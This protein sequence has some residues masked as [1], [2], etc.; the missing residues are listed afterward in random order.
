MDIDWAPEAVIEDTLS[1][2]ESHGVCCTL[3][4]THASRVLSELNSDLFEVGLHPN[5]N[6][7]LGGG[8][9]DITSIIRSLREL[10]PGAK[11]IRSHSLTQS[12]PVLDLFAKEGML[13]D[14]NQFM[15]YQRNLQPFRLWNGM[16][17][18]P[19]NWE[20]DVHMMYGK[21]FADLGLKL[22]DDQLFVL[23]FHPVHVYLNT[24]TLARYEQA[25]VHYQD[26]GQLLGYR[27]RS[28]V[29]GTRDALLQVLEFIRSG[30]HRSTTLKNWMHEWQA[31]N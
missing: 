3:F 7:L 13:Y 23:N 24:E 6:P 21:S 20:D 16:I 27:N 26:A 18:V 22:E 1:L 5:F 28:E 9:G 29:P 4:A 31:E 11:G 30:K 8:G 2:F 17:R 14:A 12:T 25:K 15:P 10:Y 19:F